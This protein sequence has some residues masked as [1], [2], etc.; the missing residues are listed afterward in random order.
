MHT[1]THTHTHACTD[2]SSLN[3][4]DV[5]RLLKG[6]VGTSVRLKCH[7]RD[8]G[9]VRPYE[10]ILK[11]ALPLAGDADY[12]VF[13]TESPRHDPSIID[14]GKQCCVLATALVYNLKSPLTTKLTALNGYTA[15]L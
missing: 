11:H 1:Y 8:G 7:N 12:E 3:V 10:V 2:V 13:A 9:T 5:G 4:K 6:P 15:D 14:K